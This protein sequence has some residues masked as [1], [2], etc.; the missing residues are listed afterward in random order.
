MEDSFRAVALLWKGADYF[1]D[2]IPCFL[3]HNLIADADVF[4]VDVVLV[5]EAGPGDGRTC[6]EGWL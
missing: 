4:V 1:G 6:K 3:D 5:V 2:Y